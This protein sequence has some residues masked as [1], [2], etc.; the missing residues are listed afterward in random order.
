MSLERPNCCVILNA[1][2]RNRT[3]NLVIKRPA[4]RRTRAA[5]ALEP[6]QGA[7]LRKIGAHALPVLVVWG[8]DDRVVPFAGSA[9]LL[10]ALPQATLLLVDSAAH[11]PHLERP[12]VVAAAVVRFLWGP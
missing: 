12:D 9:K 1:P 11:L 2:R 3:Y 8:R 4:L 7:E 6:H 5:I 10:T